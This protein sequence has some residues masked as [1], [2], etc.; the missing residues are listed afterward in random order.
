MTFGSGSEKTS[1]DHYHFFVNED[2]GDE[3]KHPA[4]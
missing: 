1:S 2:F 3:N 4:M